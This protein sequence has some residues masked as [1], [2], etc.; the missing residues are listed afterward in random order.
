MPEL[1]IQRVD[2][3]VMGRRMAAYQCGAMYSHSSSS[4]DAARHFS[5]HIDDERRRTGALAETKA[6]PPQPQRLSA[7][8][9]PVGSENPDTAVMIAVARIEEA[10]LIRDIFVQR[11]C[12]VAV[13]IGFINGR[14]QEQE[15]RQ[16]LWG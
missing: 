1:S 16:I 11:Y 4:P 13:G 15:R 7:R 10:Q 6:P 5:P 3:L 12:T 8:I 14:E 2:C 9:Q